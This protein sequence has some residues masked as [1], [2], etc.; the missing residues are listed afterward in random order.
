[1]CKL[2][3]LCLS[4]TLSSITVCCATAMPACSASAF[5][6]QIIFGM[7]LSKLD[8]Q[9]LNRLE[10]IIQVLKGKLGE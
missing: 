8:D 3:L 5:I 9:E 1:M 7:N 6:E 4:L 2:A 10:T